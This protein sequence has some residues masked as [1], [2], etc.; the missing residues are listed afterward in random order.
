MFRSMFPYP[1]AK[2]GEATMKECTTCKTPFDLSFFNKD[3]QKKDG[4]NP[5]C[6]KCSR[7]WNARNK[8]RVKAYNKNYYSENIEYQLARAKEYRQENRESI[9]KKKKDWH[10][11]NKKHACQYRNDRAEVYAAHARNRRARIKGNGGEHTGAEIEELLLKQGCRCAICKISLDSYHVDHI[12]PIAK[13]G[14]N[15]ISNLQILCP[16]CNLSKNDSDPIEYAQRN[17]FLI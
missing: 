4:L 10:L 7:A 12:Y 6:K 2:L 15:D 13:G 5:R 16:P 17:G 3:K 11:E 1:S 8:D 9:N 14:R